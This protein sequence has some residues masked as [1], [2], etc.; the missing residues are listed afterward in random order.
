MLYSVDPYGVKSAGGTNS[1][2]IEEAHGVTCVFSV[3]VVVTEDVE[4]GGCVRTF[5]LSSRLS[6]EGLLL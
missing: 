1:G 2:V 5:G 3:N 4:V 6:S